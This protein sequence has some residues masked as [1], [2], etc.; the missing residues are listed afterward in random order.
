MIRNSLRLGVV[1]AAALALVGPGLV[2][3]APAAS[4]APTLQVTVSSARLVP[5]GLQVT[6]S[7]R[8]TC[9]P[10][11]AGSDYGV[12][13]LTLTQSAGGSSTTGYGYLFLNVCDG[14]AHG[15]S[16]TVD[17]VGAPFVAGR[18]Q[19]T[20]SGYACDPSGGPCAFG[21]FGPT[22]VRIRA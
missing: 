10:F 20:G 8:Y 16:T 4:A 19:V 3:L 13:D 21:S 5:G 11:S 6:L 2:S 15:W 17:S 1:A 12:V 22:G 7:G 18:G 14:A 9:G